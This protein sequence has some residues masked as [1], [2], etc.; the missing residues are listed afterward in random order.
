MKGSNTMN[1]KKKNNMQFAQT[2]VPIIGAVLVVAGA[3]AYICLKL[4]DEFKYNEK[5]KEYDECG[6]H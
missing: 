3:I 4:A 6:W 5:W 2:L 1:E